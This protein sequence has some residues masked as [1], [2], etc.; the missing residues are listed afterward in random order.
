MSSCVHGAV[1]AR[2]FKM[3]KDDFCSAVKT[4]AC[5]QACH[6]HKDF[7]QK[8]MRGIS[9]G[10]KRLCVVVPLL[11]ALSMFWAVGKKKGH[12]QRSTIFRI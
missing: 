2:G 10:P 1:Q 8:A 11:I 7:P 12:P 4:A 5:R 6:H 9:E 3:S